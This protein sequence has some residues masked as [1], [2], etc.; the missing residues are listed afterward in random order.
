MMFDHEKE[1]F[2]SGMTLIN[3]AKEFK[4]SLRHFVKFDPLVEYVERN[5]KNSIITEDIFKNLIS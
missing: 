4:E 3:K 2:I 1:G 5:L